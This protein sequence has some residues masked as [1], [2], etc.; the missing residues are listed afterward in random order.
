MHVSSGKMQFQTCTLAPSAR[1][2][3]PP[4]G[5]SPPDEL[6]LTP[7]FLIHTDSLTLHTLT[8]HTYTHSSH[9]HR[10]YLHSLFTLSPFIPTLTQ[11]TLTVH[12]YTHSLHSHRSYLHSRN[13]H[14]YTCA[15]T[16]HNHKC[17]DSFSE[18]MYSYCRAVLSC[19]NHLPVFH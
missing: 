11:H 14:F 9:S 13:T 3:D 2:P 4:P 1:R 15:H 12:T 5:R 18:P 16:L 7:S 6:L 10:S 8:I 17:T 19:A